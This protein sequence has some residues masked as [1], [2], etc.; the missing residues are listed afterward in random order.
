MINY[1][2]SI[3]AEPNRI[4][5]YGGIYSFK[6]DGNLASEVTEVDFDPTNITLVKNRTFLIDNKIK[7]D[8]EPDQFHRI[9][10]MLFTHY[11]KYDITT[12]H[13][14]E[15]IYHSYYS[16]ARAMETIMDEMIKIFPMV[17]PWAYVVNVINLNE[18]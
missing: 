10:D 4:L 18:S 6:F 16:I 9:M 15:P 3:Y 5:C 12:N 14:D 17:K 7:M 11:E 1:N 2:G 8:L 13:V